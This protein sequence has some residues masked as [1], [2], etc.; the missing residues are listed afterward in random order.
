ME[1]GSRRSFQIQSK[2]EEAK[3]IRL[4]T[5]GRQYPSDDCRLPRYVKVGTESMGFPSTRIDGGCGPEPTFWILIFGHAI[6]KPNT[7]AASLKLLRQEDA[8]VGESTRKVVLFAYTR[9]VKCCWPT[10]I[11]GRDLM[12]RRI[13]SMAMQ[14]SDGAR[15]HPC[16]T[17][18]VVSRWP[19]SSCP[20]R[21]RTAVQT[22]E[23]NVSLD[24][25]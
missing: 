11:H 22:T 1:R 6:G 20:T 9:S 21:T 4:R 8:W 12:C 24:T 25:V 23:F 18:E 10:V 14:K 15:T 5:S 16:R 19:D 3:V 7:A 17:P 2:D 13:Q